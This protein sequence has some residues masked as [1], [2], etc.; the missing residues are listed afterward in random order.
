MEKK[1]LFLNLST[2]LCNLSSL[3]AH[4]MYKYAYTDVRCEIQIQKKN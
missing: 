3:L 4:R 2:V 1:P